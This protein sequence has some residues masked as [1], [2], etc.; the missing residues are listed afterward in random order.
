[1]R[2]GLL[3]FI[4]AVGLGVIVAIVL[5]SAWVRGGHDIDEQ[6]WRADVERAQQGQEVADWP[7]YQDVWMDTCAADDKEFKY[8]IAAFADGGDSDEVSRMNI[9]HA[10]PD[11]LSTFED[12]RDD[13]GNVQDACDTP[14]LERTASESRMAEAMDC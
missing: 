3:L 14:P 2:R 11:R 12:Y 4:S 5:V 9:R 6:A 13:I 10:C 7:A 1:M 8:T